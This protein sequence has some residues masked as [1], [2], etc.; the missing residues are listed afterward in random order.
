MANAPNQTRSSRGAMYLFVGAVLL[1]GAIVSYPWPR[2]SE[3]LIEA[4]QRQVLRDIALERLE[5]GEWRL[6]EHK[7]QAVLINYWASWCGPCRI[8]TPGLVRLSQELPGLAV[9]GVSMD[10]GDHAPVRDFV[11][12]MRVGYPIVFPAALSQIGEAMVGLPTTVLVDRQGRVAKTYMGA[13]RETE[14]R[15]DVQKVLGER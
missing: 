1:I 8:E 13:T 3:P 10:T 2:R 5:G 15:E 6:S 14:F 12:Q 11:K 4:A 9:V 7:G